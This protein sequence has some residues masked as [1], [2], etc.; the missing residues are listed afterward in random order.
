MNNNIV[1]KDRNSILFFKVWRNYNKQYINSLIITIDGEYIER[2]QEDQ[3]TYE[4]EEKLSQLPN[5]IESL[6]LDQA[7]DANILPNSLKILSFVFGCYFNQ[8]LINL[9]DSIKE[10]KFISNSKFDKDINSKL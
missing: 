3:G 8:S 1:I 10:I 2:N 7:N 5:Y 9:P 6:T 4:I